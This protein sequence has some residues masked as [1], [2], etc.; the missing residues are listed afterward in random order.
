MNKKD[1][2]ESLEEIRDEMVDEDQEKLK[3]SAK[4]NRKAEEKII[5]NSKPSGKV[6]QLLNSKK[7]LRYAATLAII[8]ATI[9]IMPMI[10]GN[11][12][13]KS[14]APDSE[15][16]KTE[17]KSANESSAP[18][19]S[20]DYK[21]EESPAES[22]DSKNTADQSG[23]ES[24][25]V[26]PTL[27]ED[28]KEKI[29]YRFSYALQTLDYKKSEDKLMTLIKDTGSYVEN[30]QIR[31]SGESLKTATYLVRVPK[32]K[33]SDFQAKVSS[34]GSLISRNISSENMTKQYRDMESNKKTLDI[35]EERLQELLKKSDKINDMIIIESKLAEIAAQ[36][37]RLTKDMDDIDHDVKYQY[38]NLELR[39]VKKTDPEIDKEDNFIQKL[40]KQFL[41]S[42]DDFVNIISSLALLLVRNWILLLV[43]AIIVITLWKISK[44]RKY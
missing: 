34:I 26:Y 14:G 29:V 24:G 25:Q 40:G 6:I 42:I 16:A 13:G 23:V 39:E 10:L 7:L 5:N 30:A 27:P 33:S 11:F 41:Y 9:A 38:F 21:S 4:L 31:D 1:I 8:I 17:T 36:K 3:S 20:G 19:E 35:K 22:T 15:T 32:E 2:K 44:K 12:G 28:S 43:L 18:S 37:E